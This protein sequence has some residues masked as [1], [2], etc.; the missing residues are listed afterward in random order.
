MSPHLKPIMNLHEQV[1]DRRLKKVCKTW[2]A[3]VHSKMRMADVLPICNSGIESSEYSFALKA[4]FDFTITDSNVC[5]LFVVEFDG[6]LHKEDPAQLGRD[7]TKNLLCKKF[8]LPILRINQNYFKKYRE[9]DLLT[10]FIEVFFTEKSFYQSQDQ[11]LIPADEPF[12]PQSI[13]YIDGS[14]DYPFWLSQ[15]ALVKISRLSEQGK[16]TDRLPSVFIGFRDNVYRGIGFLR[17]DTKQGI[18]AETAMRFQDFPVNISSV[19]DDLVVLELCESLLSCLAGRKDPKQL[20]DIENYIHK[21][22]CRNSLVGAVTSGG[23]MF[24]DSKPWDSYYKYD[25]DI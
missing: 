3:S 16:C 2:A 24:P 17:L 7:K 21:F 25:H 22:L 15:E 10:W 19:L 5:P 12:D 13:L 23:G 9:L 8:G 14:A 6:P 20:T 1:T 11:G 4:H 18:Q